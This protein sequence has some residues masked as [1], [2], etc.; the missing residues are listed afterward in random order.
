ML[1]KLSIQDYNAFQMP[2]KLEY[3]SG[4]INEESPSELLIYNNTYTKPSL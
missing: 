4:L 2:T 3:Q 1:T